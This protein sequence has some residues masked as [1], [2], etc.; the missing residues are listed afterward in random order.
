M[1][2]PN[3]AEIAIL[4]TISIAELFGVYDLYHLTYLSCVLHNLV[5]GSIIWLIIITYL[6]VHLL[7]LFPALMSSYVMACAAH[8]L[9]YQLFGSC[10]PIV[11]STYISAVCYSAL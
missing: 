4:L 5:W 2:I 10:G 1:T 7:Y 3:H 11:L 8:A 9:Y 6:P